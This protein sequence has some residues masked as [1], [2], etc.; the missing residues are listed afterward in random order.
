MARELLGPESEIKLEQKEAKR[1]QLGLEKCFELESHFT[2][3]EMEGLERA[4]D[5]LMG[6]K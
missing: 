4:Y 3:E 6:L 5:V 1:L 2:E